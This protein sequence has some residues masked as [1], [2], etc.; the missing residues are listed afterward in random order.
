MVTALDVAAARAAVQAGADALLPE[1][2]DAAALAAG[3]ARLLAGAAAPAG[4]A[5]A[6][7]NPERG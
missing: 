4:G 2:F 7:A 5:A 3:A 6:P 1:P